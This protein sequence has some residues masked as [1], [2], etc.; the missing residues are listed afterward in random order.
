MVAKYANIL[1]YFHH[2]PPASD[3]TSKGLKPVLLSDYLFLLTT[4]TGFNIMNLVILFE[5]P[6]HS[7]P[8]AL[9]LVSDHVWSEAFG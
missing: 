5:T 8:P 6:P 4:Q 3:E 7:T 9:F 2:P 1:K